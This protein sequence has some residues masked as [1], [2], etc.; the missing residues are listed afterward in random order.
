MSERRFKVVF[1]I[2]VE[3]DGNPF[4][5]VELE[6]GDC[7]HHA[8]SAIQN[9]LLEAVTKMNQWGN[10]LSRGEEPDFQK[11]L[12]PDAIKAIWS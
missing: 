1:S 8:M 9:A 11:P 7:P 10:A 3:E 6:Y 4:S 12:D 2:R 5:A